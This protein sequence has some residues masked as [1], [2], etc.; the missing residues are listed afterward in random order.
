MGP[1]WHKPSPGRP[2]PMYREPSRGARRALKSEIPILRL[3]F[4]RP[5]GARATWMSAALT[6]ELCL[7]E[8]V[9]AQYVREVLM[10]PL[11]LPAGTQLVVSRFSAGDYDF[12]FRD[13]VLQQVAHPKKET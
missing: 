3:T 5:D 1:N 8:A 7:D 6:M 10:P 4:E 12:E 11:G 2:A 13:G 9:C